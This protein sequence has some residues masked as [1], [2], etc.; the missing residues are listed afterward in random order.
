MVVQ[1][2]QASIWCGFELLF[3]VKLNDEQFIKGKQWMC[4][5]IEGL[6]QLYPNMVQ[7]RRYLHERPE[8][9][10]HERQ[11]ARFISSLLTQWGVDVQLEVAGHSVIGT[12]QGMTPGPTI[13]LRADIDALPIQDEKQCEYRSQVAG[14][15]HACGH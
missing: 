9:S 15:M 7:W 2:N 11:T 1:V 10:F 14:V 5:R 13:A 12:L 3:P 8:L 4:M 6:D